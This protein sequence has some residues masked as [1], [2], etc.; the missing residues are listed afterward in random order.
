[1]NKLVAVGLLV[2]IA[3]TLYAGYI[4]FKPATA[5]RLRFGGV[6]LAVDI[7]ATSADQERGLSFRDSMAPDHGM[8]FVF[9]QEGM[10][11]F[12]MKDMRFSL[13]IIWFDSQR[14]AVFIEQSLPPCTPQNCPI[15]TPPVNALYVLEVN[16]G[17]VQAHTVSLGDTFSFVS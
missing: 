14:R 12:W 9:Q 11:G 2:L 6:V 13:D 5:T 4:L 10:W 16:A 17:F 3:G 8:L 1:M 15:F 7:A